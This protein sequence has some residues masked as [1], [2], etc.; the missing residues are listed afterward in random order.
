M[1]CCRTT[2]GQEFV[3]SH[4]KAWLRKL[5]HATRLRDVVVGRSLVNQDAPGCG[6]SMQGISLI[7]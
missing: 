2:A 3:E 4:S 5:W 7:F 6:K 1:S